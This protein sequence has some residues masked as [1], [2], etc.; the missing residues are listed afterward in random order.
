MHTGIP[1]QS[2][3]QDINHLENFTMKCKFEITVHKNKTYAFGGL[4]EG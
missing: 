4:S 1:L 3:A 2:R